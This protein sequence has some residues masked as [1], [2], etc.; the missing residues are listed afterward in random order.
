M[1]LVNQAKIDASQI[2]FTTRF[3]MELLAVE[4]PLRE[5]AMELPSNAATEDHDWLQA[6][7]GL[8]EWVDDRKLDSLTAEKIT[9]VN[10]DWSNGI[11][12]KKNDILDDKLQ[13]IGLRLGQLA[14]KAGLHYGQRIVDTLINGFATTSEFGAAYDG[15]AYFATTHPRSGPGF[16]NQSNTA[17]GAA[18]TLANYFA[19]RAAMWKITDDVGDELSNKPDTLVCGPDLE[20]TA[21][22]I[23]EADVVPSAA[24]TASKSNVA[25]GTARVIISPRLAGA[26]ANHWF[27]LS[28]NQAVKP[29]I[30]QIR[31]A[32]TSSQTE[33]NSDDAFMRKHLKFGAEARHNTGF[34]LWQFAYGSNA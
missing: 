33:M 31:D 19:G 10:K 14:V 12:I 3:N 1:G 5:I 28:L 4:D 17:G 2:G 29:I 9:I 21:L 7:P 27:L 34:G 16:G 30:L 22:E 26:T 13:I 32:I 11:R 15:V 25:R 24:A 23:V 20:Q 6:V 18:L 8:T